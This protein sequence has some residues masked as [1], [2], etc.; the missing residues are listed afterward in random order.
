M[1]CLTHLSLIYLTNTD[2]KDLLRRLMQSNPEERI[3]MDAIMSHPWLNEGHSLPFG[4]APFPN[5]LL[6]NDV[7]SDIVEH[8]VHILKV[9]IINTC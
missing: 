2:C 1:Q 6:P 7:D 5:K 4:P 9:R 3:K 8:M